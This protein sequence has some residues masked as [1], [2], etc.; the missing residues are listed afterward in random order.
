MFDEPNHALVTARAAGKAL[1]GIIAEARKRGSG[2]LMTALR[3]AGTWLRV[4]QSHTRSNDDGR[5]VLTAVVVL[6]LQDLD[7]VAAGDPAIRKRMGAITER[8]R[9]LEARLAEKRLAVVGHH[10]DY[11]PDNIFIGERRV[12]A[13]DFSSYRE[14]LPLEDVA[15][16]LVHLELHAGLLLSRQMPRLRRALLDGYL[17][18]EAVDDDQLQLALLAKALQTLARGGSTDDRQRRTLHAILGRVTA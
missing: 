18:N 6:A 3:R 10:G 13:I 4:M 7:L 15:Q 11:A 1:S 12:E 9:S 14:G 5:H 2:R 17:S 8:L 16:L